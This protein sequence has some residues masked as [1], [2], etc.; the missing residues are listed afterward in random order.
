M[1]KFFYRM[2]KIDIWAWGNQ[3][4]VKIRINAIW[5]YNNFKV[6]QLEDYNE[7]VWKKY[8]VKNNHFVMR[9]S[10]ILR[11]DTL[12]LISKFFRTKLFL[13]QSWHY[14]THRPHYQLLLDRLACILII[15]WFATLQKYGTG[16][17]YFVISCH[18]DCLY[19][20]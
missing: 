8:L 15:T 19:L 16:Y 14:F 12:C 4:N 20:I 10:S 13:G 17:L 7:Q 11:I 5:D 18:G 9:G 1:V 3:K 2:V 6:F